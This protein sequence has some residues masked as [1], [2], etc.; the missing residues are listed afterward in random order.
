MHPRSCKCLR[1]RTAQGAA[2]AGLLCA[3]V[4]L[5]VSSGHEPVCCRGAGCVYLTGTL[6]ARAWALLCQAL[7][8]RASADVGRV[9][10][11]CVCIHAASRGRSSACVCMC[12]C[13][14][15]CARGRPGG[16]GAVR[17]DMCGMCKIAVVRVSRAGCRVR[18]VGATWH[19]RC[20]P[21]LAVAHCRAGRIALLRA[22]C[23][24]LRI[25]VFPLPPSASGILGW[26][27]V[28]GGFVLTVQ[29]FQEAG[30]ARRVFRA[31]LRVYFCRK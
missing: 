16:L 20:G 5:S 2:C 7:S 11:S 23:I 29:V 9:G 30:G 3:C 13:V 17:S 24:A 31:G 26:F 28:S 12:V 18:L 19:A 1:V 8:V 25:P 6:C 4:P 10:Y 15:V 27:C 21:L 14:V 22:C